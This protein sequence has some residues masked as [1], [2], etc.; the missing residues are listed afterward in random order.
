MA[1][2]QSF[3]PTADD[4][5]AVSTE[6]LALVL[7]RLGA[8]RRQR[9]MFWP[10]SV[11]DMTVGS[12]IATETQHVYPHNKR[13]QIDALVNEGWERLRRDGLILPAPD[14][15]GANGF[16]VLSRDGE[17]A[18]ASPD[19]FERLKAAR[20]FPKELLHPSIAKKVSA[21]LSRGDYDEALREAFTIVE[22]SVREA[23]GCPATD[24]G[25]DLMRTAF[26]AKNG[27]L[28]DF[29]L[30]EAEREGYAHLFAGAIGAFKNPHSH[31]VLGTSDIRVA[32]DQ[33]L[34]ASQLLR[35]IDAAKDRLKA[36]A[37]LSSR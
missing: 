5:L 32:Q 24:I 7:L 1:T 25:K 21:A 16:M 28:T 18:L 6:D 23:A 4:L 10:M 30:P 2:L 3:F 27:K 36:R 35:I 13:S 37:A 26:N 33:V 9:G 22:V 34:L 11:T 12:G 19:A 31:R 20:T 14:I 15:N 17:A 8:E 29:S